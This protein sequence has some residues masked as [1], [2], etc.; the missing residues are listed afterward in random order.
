MK[1][2]RRAFSLLEILIVTA[3][4]V[5]VGAGLLISGARRLEFAA[6]QAEDSRLEQI[7]ADILR[8]LD[9]E[10]Y[11]ST[12]LLALA[13]V[14]PGAVTP[15]AFNLHQHG[16]FHRQRRPVVFK[17]RAGARP[18]RDP[19]RRGLSVGPTRTL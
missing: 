1:P 9:S 17:S 6:I 8:S 4:I 15:T 2:S 10:D 3:I 19:W 7:S 16:R 13:G 18:Q 14:I 11:A 12:N 5:A